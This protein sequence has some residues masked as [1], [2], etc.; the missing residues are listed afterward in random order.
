[1]LSFLSLLVGVGETSSYL[2]WLSRWPR[3]AAALLAGAS[4]AVAGFLL[5]L[6]T[7]NRFVEPATVGTN[8]A[9]SLGL[10]LIAI[11]AP[12]A[13]VFWKML[14]A[15]VFALIGTG[16]FLLI[17]Q[18]V[19]TRS[20]FTVPLVGIMLGS[21]IGAVATFLAYRFDLLQAL[22]GWR[23]GSFASVLKGRYELLWLVAIAA[24]IMYLAA[25]RF[26]LLSLGEDLAINAGV[27]TNQVRWLGLALVAIVSAINVVTIGSI[28]FLGLVV[29]G[30]AAH[31]LGENTRFALPWVALGGATLTLACDLIGR[32]IRFPFEIPVGTILG[33]LGGVIFIVM[34][35]QRNRRG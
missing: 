19:K 33:V 13:P 24:V 8:E 2:V 23:L 5:Q 11:V 28:P 18:R 27:R 35:L 9:A 7:R 21:V 31:Y 17:V 10:V 20:L 34:L 25:D 6:L 26:T 3:T 16:I 32:L 14:A 12:G 29:P 30:L 22:G 4:L 1:M 15:T